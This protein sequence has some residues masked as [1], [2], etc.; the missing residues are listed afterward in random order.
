M[1]EIKIEQ[2]IDVV[3]EAATLMDRSGGFEIRNK[4]VLED[5]V[6]SSDVAIQH[7]LTEKL[8]SL[9]PGSGFLCEEEDLQDLNHRYIWIIDPI[10][11]TA[12]YA[13]GNEN[14]CISVG[15]VK[16]KELFMG[17]VYSPWRGEL[18]TAV[19]GEGAFCNGKP[20]HV[21]DRPF[22]NGLLY[23]AMSTYHKEW[24]RYC[25][26]VIFDLYNQSNDVRRTGSAAIELCLLASGYADLY[27]EIRIMPW[28]YAAASLILKEAG[29]AA[30]SFDGDSPSLFRPSMY[31]AA[32]TRQ[33]CDRILQTV[34]RHIRQLPY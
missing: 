21:S 26:D 11:G 33:N 5:L 32:N 10:D 25:S 8:G 27:F 7:F 23:T 16:D 19:Q 28:D 3:R 24:S 34:R 18:Y 22:E 1:E 30:C 13:R 29:G 31:I 20:I 14:C 17:V 12:N 2:I 15:L 6:T 9:L 4:S